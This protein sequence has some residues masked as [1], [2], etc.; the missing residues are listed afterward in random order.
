MKDILEAYKYNNCIN[1]ENKHTDLCHIV[2]V[3]ENDIKRARCVWYKNNQIE[4]RKRSQVN[5]QEW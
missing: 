2:V 4:K 3:N 5:W 1:C